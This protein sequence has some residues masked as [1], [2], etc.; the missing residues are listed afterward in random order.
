M[1]F[2]IGLQT[3][4]PHIL[5]LR[6][7]EKPSF[8]RYPLLHPWLGCPSGST[9][10][11][12]EKEVSVFT[13]QVPSLHDCNSRIDWSSSQATVSVPS[14]SVLVT[15]PFFDLHSL[16]GGKALALGYEPVFVSLYMVP[17]WNF[18]LLPSLRFC[19]LLRPWLS[20]GISSKY[21]MVPGPLFWLKSEVLSEPVC[22]E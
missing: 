10:V 16:R 4:Y 18:P 7:I 19:L 17:L 5:T 22:M 11:K 1:C 15:A 2:L 3:F 14:C 21:L 8:D 13:L 6:I 20:Q 12:M 9:D